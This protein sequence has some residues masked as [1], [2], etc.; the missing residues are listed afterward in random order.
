MHIGLL[1][2]RYLCSTYRPYHNIHLYPTDYYRIEHQAKLRMED[3]I[4]LKEKEAPQAN[5]AWVEK[6][7]PGALQDLISHEGMQFFLF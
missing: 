7:R 4:E 5:I 6:Y 2:R 1:I 3:Q